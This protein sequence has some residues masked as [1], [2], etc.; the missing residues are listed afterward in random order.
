MGLKAGLDLRLRRAVRAGRAVGPGAGPHERP[1]VVSLRV[2]LFPRL[3]LALIQAYMEG[4]ARTHLH[5]LLRH[6]T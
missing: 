3:C 2:Q 5:H 1:L 6:I 4:L